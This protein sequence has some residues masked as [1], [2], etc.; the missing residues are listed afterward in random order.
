MLHAVTPVFLAVPSPLCTHTD[1]DG[2]SSSPLHPTPD[3]GARAAVCTVHLSGAARL[4]AL[5]SHEPLLHVPPHHGARIGAPAQRIYLG[6]P[7]HLRLRADPRLDERREAHYAVLGHA[8]GLMR[9]TSPRTTTHIA[10]RA[11]IPPAPASSAPR[12]AARGV[13]RRR[14]AHGTPC[15]AAQP[16]A[17]RAAGRSATSR[18]TTTPHIS[19]SGAYAPTPDSSA[20]PR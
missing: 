11:H 7:T 10:H 9:R 15:A 1:G 14:R 5:E 6:R 13:R 18:R 4:R 20:P 17:S 19:A 12:R 2:G 3:W 16:C 8:A